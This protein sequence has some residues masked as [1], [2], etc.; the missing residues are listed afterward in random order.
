MSHDARR[1]YWEELCK[2]SNAADWVTFLDLHKDHL[3][4]RDEPEHMNTLRRFLDIVEALN[5]NSDDMEP[6]RLPLDLLL[7]PSDPD[8]REAR[9]IKWIG[10]RDETDSFGIFNRV[11]I[12]VN[13]IALCMYLIDKVMELSYSQKCDLFTNL[14]VDA[15]QTVTNTDHFI[16]MQEWRQIGLLP[17]D[18]FKTLCRKIETED[19]HDWSVYSSLLQNFFMDIGVVQ[20]VIRHGHPQIRD[21]CQFI[22][23]GVNR[24]VPNKV[25]F[26]IK[27]R[28][29]RLT[30]NMIIEMMDV[31]M[32]LTLCQSP[33]GEEEKE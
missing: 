28:L 32:L 6:V 22:E 13:N 21:V 4:V 18:I 15:E 3:K 7:R 29:I 16:P 30:F 26:K 27:S 11:F 5:L 14:I 23:S 19:V 1:D 33:E 9:I 31:D 17:V 12:Y 8:E 20:Y 24:T 2:R 10:H 25:S